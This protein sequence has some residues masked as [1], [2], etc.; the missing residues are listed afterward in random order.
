[1]KTTRNET[2]CKV[3]DKLKTKGLFKDIGGLIAKSWS[4]LTADYFVNN[5]LS[6]GNSMLKKFREKGVTLC[7]VFL[8]RR[9]GS[10]LSLGLILTTWHALQLLGR[11]DN[12]RDF[13]RRGEREGYIQIWLNTGRPAPDTEVCVKRILD[14]NE[15][16]SEWRINGELSNSL[17]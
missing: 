15:N 6:L 11:A 1:M 7:A 10:Y 9:P 2:I 3:A 14:G 4:R 12:V 17:V 16:K 13:V 5:W 8:G